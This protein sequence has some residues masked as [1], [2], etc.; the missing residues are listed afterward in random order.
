MKNISI[1]FLV[2]SLYLFSCTPEGRA[3]T[4]HE[5]REITQKEFKTMLD[6]GQIDHVEVDKKKV[7]VFLNDDAAQKLD[8]LDAPQ[9][10]FFIDNYDTFLNEMESL[11]REYMVRPAVKE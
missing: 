5:G 1:L 8:L 3:I 7:F 4:Q 10:N 9:Y 2:F 11:D 6:A